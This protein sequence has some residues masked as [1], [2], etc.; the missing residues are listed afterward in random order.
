MDTLA[1]KRSLCPDSEP[2]A[3][4]APRILKKFDVLGSPF[5]AKAKLASAASASFQGW[6]Q[7]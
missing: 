7:G 1:S 2:G 4:R 5:F 6:F 3:S